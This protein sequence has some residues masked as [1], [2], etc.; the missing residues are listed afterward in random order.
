MDL[1]P[2]ELGQF[3]GLDARLSDPIFQGKAQMQPRLV[4][5]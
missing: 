4:D 2:S 1:P 3:H 5:P